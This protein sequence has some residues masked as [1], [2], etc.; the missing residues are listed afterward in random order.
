MLRDV[1]HHVSWRSLGFHDSTL[2]CCLSRLLAVSSGPPSWVL[3]CHPPTDLRHPSDFC[4]GFH[5]PSYALMVEPLHPQLQ[6]LSLRSVPSVWTFF[7]RTTWCFSFPM[8]PP[9]WLPDVWNVCAQHGSPPS[10]SCTHPWTHSVTRDRHCELWEEPLSSALS[11]LQPGP[12]SAVYPS[13]CVLAE[14]S[15]KPVPP[16]GLFSGPLIWRHFSPLLVCWAF[17]RIHI[18]PGCGLWVARWMQSAVFLVC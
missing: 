15:R 4:R 18:N 5:L 9:T 12:I 7:P 2:C 11:D 1:W 10:E 17:S 8:E 16:S 13:L 6:M 3:S 14:V